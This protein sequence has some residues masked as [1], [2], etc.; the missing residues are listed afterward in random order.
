LV[1]DWDGLTEYEIKRAKMLAAKG[2]A[3]FTADLF[4]AGLRPKTRL[5]KQ[6][7]TGELY[8]DRAKFRQLLQG[9]LK[10]AQK[11]GASP[12]KAVAIGYC[13]GGAAVLELARSGADLKGFVSF[14]GGLDTPKGQDYAQ[15]KGEIFVFHGTADAHIKMTDFAELAQELEMHNVKH[16]MTTYSSAPHAFTVFGSSSYRKEADQK[17]WQRFLRFLAEVK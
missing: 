14:H 16:E 1:H 7:L 5:H 11:Q 8:K 4:G 17:S 12:K 10:V 9:S 3:V 6:K 2:Y 13:F 15:T